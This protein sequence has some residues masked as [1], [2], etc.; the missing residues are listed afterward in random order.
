MSKQEIRYI[1]EQLV[2]KGFIK[3]TDYCEECG[4]VGKVDAHHY[5]YDNPFNVICLCK[6]CH[7]KKHGDIMF[8]TERIKANL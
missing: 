3:L 2:R 6:D 7:H 4:R 1:T 5:N 8:N